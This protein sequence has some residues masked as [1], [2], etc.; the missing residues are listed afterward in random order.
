MAAGL[1]ACQPTLIGSSALVTVTPEVPAFARLHLSNE[2][3][4]TVAR[5]ERP[6]LSVTINENLVDHLRIRT[7]GGSLRIALDED[8]DYERL[9][10]EAQAVTPSLAA[11]ELSGASRARLVGFEAIS[12][13][14]F[15]ADLSGASALSG[16]VTAEQLTLDLSGASRAD[17]GGVARVLDLDLSGASRAG[18]EGLPVESAGVALSGASRADVRADGEVRG[19]AS[20]ASSLTVRGSAVI[21]VETSGGSAISRR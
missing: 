17:V 6:T 21:R 13:P 19:E 2:V 10:A 4:A 14:K 9:H 5:G 8:Y 7:E 12:V 16:A 1:S 3:D 11:V 20:G 18:L 15:A